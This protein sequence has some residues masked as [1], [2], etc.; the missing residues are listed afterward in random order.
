[1]ISPKLTLWKNC[2]VVKKICVTHKTLLCK[3]Y[4]TLVLI[5]TVKTFLT[6]LTSLKLSTWFRHFTR[7]DVDEWF[8]ASQPDRFQSFDV[9]S[10]KSAQTL[11]FINEIG[12]TTYTTLDAVNES[13]IFSSR[14]Q[15]GYVSRTP[16]WVWD[17][18]GTVADKKTS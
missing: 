10:G 14:Y 13:N 1:M 12:Q 18:S 2:L 11:K 8:H 3:L 9:Y 7:K 17:S 16:Q 5:S 15:K 4:K 6:C